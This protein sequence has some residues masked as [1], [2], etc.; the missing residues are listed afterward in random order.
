MNA[1]WHKNRP[2]A[3]QFSRFKVS[4]QHLN[5]PPAAEAL[6][7]K[8]PSVQLTC[9]LTAVCRYRPEPPGEPTLSCPE[10]AASRPGSGLTEP[11]RAPQSPAEPR[12]SPQRPAESSDR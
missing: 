7:V 3:A 5:A 10:A 11:R 8:E 2:T 9:E 12:R 4:E 6:I 1:I